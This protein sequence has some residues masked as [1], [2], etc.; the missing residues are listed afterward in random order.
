MTTQE[1][2]ELMP[3]IERLNELKARIAETEGRDALSDTDFARRFLPFSSTT[4]SKLQS[5]TYGGG[6]DTIARRLDDAVADVEG[7]LP[8]IESAAAARRTFRRTTLARAVLAALS[9][10]R[11]GLDDR[12]VVVVLAPTGGGKTAIRDYLATRNAVCVEGRQAWRS[13][14]RAFCLDVAR[15]AGRKLPATMPEYRIEDEMLGALRAK[16]RVLFIDE[17]NT[18]SA[19]CANA[20]KSIVNETECC[21][22]IAAIPELWD[23]FLAG[24]VQEAAQLVNRCQPIL[25]APRISAADARLFLGEKAAGVPGAVAKI[26]AAANAFGGFRTVQAVNAALEECDRPGEDDL[27]AALAMQRNNLA[28]AG[29]AATK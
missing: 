7:R 16:P 20:I 29:L 24:S 28:A 4:W 6:Y 15:A 9:A 2:N 12:R 22:V 27:D 18:M 1:I 13:S 8:N 26:A 17:A 11:E 25:R 10:A 23:R 5:G 14:Y 19:K 21:V 3:R